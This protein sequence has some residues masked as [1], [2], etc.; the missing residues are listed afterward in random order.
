MLCTKETTSWRVHHCLVG[1]DGD[2]GPGPALVSGDTAAQRTHLAGDVLRLAGHLRSTGLR[3]GERVGVLMPRGIP[4]ATTLLACST[5]GLVSVPLDA[6]N[7]SGYLQKLVDLSGPAAVLTAGSDVPDIRVPE[8]RLI[9]VT[10]VLGS[11][12]DSMPTVDPEQLASWSA[13]QDQFA[14]LFTS[15][16]TG[17]PKGVLTPHGC[18]AYRSRFLTAALGG[19]RSGQVHLSH[20]PISIPRFVGQISWALG[21]GDSVVLLEPLAERDPSH[22]LSVLADHRVS[23]IFLGATMLRMLLMV[24]PHLVE[25]EALQQIVVSGE[26]FPP[27]LEEELRASKPGIEIHQCYGSAEANLVTHFLSGRDAPG[28][29]GRP[30]LS[31]IVVLDDDRRPCPTGTVGEVW[32]TNDG[33]ASGYLDDEALTHRAFQAVDL[34]A[35]RGSRPWCRLGDLARLRDDGCLE[36]RGR[37][38]DQVKI[39]GFRVNLA[40]IEAGILAHPQVHA[41]AILAAPSGAGGGLVAFVAAPELTARQLRADLLTRVPRHMVPD[42]LRVLGELPMRNGKIDRQA[43][44][45]RLT[46]PAIDQPRS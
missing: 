17:I 16:S 8:A 5:A 10:A 28:T 46:D 33:M 30:L 31:E 12:T 13:D 15:G 40:E 2:V 38:D 41:A 39:R 4:A 29:V 25:A 35:D 36:L 32:A 26:A 7:P 9:D 19:T 11:A 3:K 18:F 34:D 44:R 45:S 37:R 24:S 27:E 23:T 43:L 42:R 22:V 20:S 1:P 21:R 14:I 6:G